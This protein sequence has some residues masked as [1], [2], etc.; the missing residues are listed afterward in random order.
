MHPPNI[1]D[2]ELNS[3]RSTLK[4]VVILVL[5]LKRDS[6][7]TV[8]CVVLGGHKCKTPY[9]RKPEKDIYYVR[10]DRLEGGLR[11]L[12]SAEH[13]MPTRQAPNPNDVVLAS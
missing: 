12:H 1:V 2:N 7:E 13:A 5:M 6:I 3:F 11:N 10:R 8:Q 9:S 4:Y